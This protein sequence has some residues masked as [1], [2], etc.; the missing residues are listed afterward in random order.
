MRLGVTRQAVQQRWGPAPRTAATAAIAPEP[1]H[2]SGP[3][4]TADDIR[5]LR[6][7]R[8]GNASS[9]P[10]QLLT[11][12]PAT[13]PHHRHR[14]GHR[15]DRHRL[16][17][18]REPGACC[19]SRAATAANPPARPA[20]PLYKRDARQLVRSGLTG[21]KGIPETVAAHPCVFATF[22][23]PSFGPVHARRERGKVLPCRPRRD[24]SKRT[25]PHGRDISCPVRHHEDDP[26][27]GRPMCPDCYDYQSAVVF[28]ASAGELWRRFT[29]Y[30][31]RHLPAWLA[32]T[33]KE[34][35]AL[36]RLRFVKVAEYQARG[37]VHFHAIIRLDATPV[38]TT[39][40]RRRWT[41]AMLADAIQ[42]AASAAS[43]VADLAGTAVARLRRA[44][45]HAGY[46]PVTFAPRPR[47]ELPGGGELHR[48]VR[49]QDPGAPGLPAYR[50]RTALEVQAL[51]CPPTTCSVTTAWELGGDAG[52]RLGYGSGRTASATAA[53]SSPNP[54]AS[55]SPSA[56][57]APHAPNTAAPSATQTANSTP[58]AATSTRPSSWSSVT[59][60]TPVP[61]TRHPTLS[62]PSCPPMARE[63]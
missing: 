24:A 57:S 11:P 61:A 37:V 58:G 34:L 42:A 20:R 35:R 48:Q 31:P 43:V 26:R 21:G 62:W 15:R 18:R 32:V 60:T 10:P 49:H 9:P 2:G 3:M 23:A 12:H 41:A 30:L 54:A 28:N 52:R 47:A 4:A 63:R 6:R 13:R 29:T 36:V 59:G 55:P 40:P 51:R 45:R 17:H 14:P 1:E 56:S 38:T 25:C 50:L 39:C 22:T 33:Q 46:P 53:T 19:T 27:L 5:P 44:D 16:H 7:L 8:A